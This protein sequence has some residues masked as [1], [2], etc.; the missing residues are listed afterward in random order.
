MWFADPA[1]N[2]AN[3]NFNYAF[4]HDI[5][6]GFH[7]LNEY[8]IDKARNDLKM[9]AESVSDE[10]KSILEKLLDIDRKVA[11][12]MANDMLF[13]GIDPVFNKLLNLNK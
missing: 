3:I 4:Y 11:V 2:I 12:A 5:C 10:E 8:F 6:F 9:R 7:R 13:G 1:S